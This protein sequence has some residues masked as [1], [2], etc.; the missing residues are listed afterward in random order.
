MKKIIFAVCALLAAFSAQCLAEVRVTYDTAA[1]QIKINVTGIEKQPALISVTEGRYDAE[2][3]PSERKY[4]FV[5]EL[6]SDG[7]LECEI[8]ADAPSGEY[9]VAAS[10]DGELT[11]RSVWHINPA[12]AEDALKRL[13][14]A[15][16]ADEVA[17]I[18]D[19][20]YEKLA[21]DPEEF[22]AYRQSVSKNFLALFA[23][24]KKTAADFRSA[25]GSALAIAKASADSANAE[26]YARSYAG[27]LGLDL[28]EFDALP[29]AAKTEFLRLFASGTINKST[30]AE[31]M[32]EFMFLAKFN[33]EKSWTVC[34]DLII[35]EY[36]DFLGID[37]A[38]Y[39]KLSNGEGVIKKLMNKTPY[40]SAA[41]LVSDFN[42]A[43]DSDS[44][45]GSTGG[46][47]SSGGSSGSSSGGSGGVSS[48]GYV[49]TDISGTV[50]VF[51]DVPE[52]HWAYSYVKDLCARGV[53]KGV[54]ETHFCPQNGITRAEFATLLRAMFYK[55]VP[56]GGAEL[57]DVHAG[58][59]YYEPICVLNASGIMFGDENGFFNPNSQITR[60][61]VCVMLQRILALPAGEADFADGD[62]ISG[63]AAEAVGSLY[64]NGIISGRGDNLFAPQDTMT[65][66]EAA[67]ILCRA[68][69]RSRG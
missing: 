41:A 30:P 62:A 48:G 44:G 56:A 22:S 14:A 69:E 45:S 36:K 5:K 3:S 28:D 1:P 65:R 46:G 47:G 27:E 11:T 24:T 20:E 51:D 34:R 40:S 61:D 32:T 2:K 33:T 66:A 49:N 67:A 60:Q 7:G 6:Y 10:V 12:L 55:S 16:T 8:P 63:Y 21:V 39:N 29:D 42:A 4:V 9:T 23:G 25:Y 50:G 26:K 17:A 59:W 54:D 64:Q 19:A 52:G 37:A 68:S 31:Q 57:A 38:K 53:I 35:V 15:K 18:I 43:E 13:A 58:D